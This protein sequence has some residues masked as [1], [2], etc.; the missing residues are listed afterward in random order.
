M[1]VCVCVCVCVSRKGHKFDLWEAAKVPSTEPAVTASGNSSLGS[2]G[3]Y[4]VYFAFVLYPCG[5]QH[6]NNIFQ[7]HNE[8]L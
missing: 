7:S 3:R 5:V 1:C 4:S 2:V 8:S 6:I